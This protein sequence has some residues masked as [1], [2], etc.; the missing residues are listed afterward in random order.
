[1]NK[2]SVILVVLVGLVAKAQVPQT[3]IQYG[4]TTVTLTGPMN[5][6]VS[7]PC[8]SL[9]SQYCISVPASMVVV[10]ASTTDPT[11]VAYTVTI[12]YKLGIGA[13]R[14]MTQVVQ[15][16]PGGSTVVQ[17]QVPSGISGLTAQVNPGHYTDQILE[18]STGQ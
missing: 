8:F 15:V 3:M 7:V 1:M 4:P 18:L 2:I 13:A 11:V 14:S 10:S 12:G 5:T 16:T 9:P 6:V 17:F